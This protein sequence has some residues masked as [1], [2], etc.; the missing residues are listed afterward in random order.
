M[1]PLRLFSSALLLLGAIP[2]GLG[3]ARPVE[4]TQRPGLLVTVGEVTA[5]RA[6]LWLRADEPAPVIVR[7]APAGD[8]ASPRRLRLEPAA[9]R[10]LTARAAL[11]ALQPGTRYAY[12]V[13]QGPVS[14]K[15]VFATAPPAD[16]DAPARLQ[17]SGDL[18]GGGRCRDVEDGYRIFRA[19]AERAPDLF[20][21]VGDTIYADHACGRRAHA[22]G[23]DFV[24]STLAEYHAKHRY[25]RAD[26]ELQRF[27]RT[28][29]VYAIWDDHE[30]T[31]DFDGP[32]EPLMPAGRQAFVDYWPVAG[33]PGEPQRLYR[34]V[35][36]GRHADIFI[37]D[38]RQYR[39]PR[40][41][42]D[43]PA[44]SMLGAAQRGWLL[45][46]VSRS[47][48]TW[49]LVVSSLPLGMFTGGRISDSWSSANVLGFPRRNGTGYVFERDHLL[50]AFRER[51]VRNLV[52][53]TGEVHHAQLVRH[54]PAPGFVLHEFSAGPLSARQGYPRPMDRS[55][56]SRSLGSLGFADNFGELTVSGDMLEVRIVDGA[57][58]VRVALTLPADAGALAGGMAPGRASREPRNPDAGTGGRTAAER[59]SRPL[60]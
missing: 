57:G 42:P 19:M 47:D 25:N 34:R 46:G 12:E 4:D 18:G 5:D 17:W 51:G 60:R 49:K 14:V 27:F 35:R 33:P 21:F 20:L 56:N 52:F 59:G 37:L 50:A 43:G 53:L 9:R 55:L 7:Y 22:P 15:G 54:E 44:K 6:A 26:R 1:R 30:V 45:D 38:T 36:W 13:A 23:G 24:A 8:A 58:T 29:P 3:P 11:T 2:T 31:N 48:A 40:A 41:T 28:A 39:S 32:A 16:A 10:D